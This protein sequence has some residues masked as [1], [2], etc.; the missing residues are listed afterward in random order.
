MRAGRSVD[1][2]PRVARWQARFAA[3]VLIIAAALGGCASLS[4]VDKPESFS[5]PAE[6]SDPLVQ[7]AAASVPSAGLSSFRPLPFSR[8]SL[9]AR[10]TL[11]RHAVRS[12]D[13]QYY[14]LQ[15]DS[16]GRA[17]LRE[18]RDAAQRGVRVRILVDDLYTA[19][20]ED[21]LMQL[22]ATDNIEVRLFNPF[23]AGRAHAL[24][25]WTFS[26][27]DFARVNHR[28]HNKMFVA[29]GAF[30]VVGGRNMADEY[31]FQSRTGNFV[32]FDL[33]VAGDAV[34]RMAQIFDSYWNSKRVYPLGALVYSK[35]SREALALRFDAA[36]ASDDGPLTVAASDATDA[37]GFSLLSLDLKASSPLKML[38]GSMEVF[39]DTPEKA[40]GKS[41][42]GDDAS[43]VTSRV[44]NALTQARSTVVVASPYF[45]PGKLGMK[46]IEAIRA[47]GVRFTLITNSLGAND[48]PYASVAYSRYRKAMLAMGVDIYE[49][50]SQ[51]LRGNRDVARVLGTTTGRSHAKIVVIDGNT[52]FVG[53]MNM[54]LRSSRENTELGALVHSEALA[55]EVSALLDSIRA[56]G[57][58]HLRL[59]PE[60]DIEWVSGDL[61]Q[62]RVQRSEPEVDFGTRLKILLFAPF[63]AESLL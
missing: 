54:D 18:L 38:Q 62:E 13:V 22:A 60:Q 10:I 41:E 9:D 5:I 33:L 52:T 40:S 31:F 35:E 46:A 43:T 51:E 11:A 47:R 3:L 23:P 44:V 20:T 37:L 4:P 45:V 57:A 48:E 17:L 50:S 32:D 34:P 16:I 2:T 49:V 53:S 26:L 29:D 61:G 59:S 36:A 21:L 55:A 42:T 25:R 56:H 6:S 7:V 63:I 14:L 1:A 39:A 24:T 12:L 30:A 28:M 8:F 27:L 19:S 58:Y 15:N